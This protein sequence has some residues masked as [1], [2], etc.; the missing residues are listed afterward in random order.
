VGI[1]ADPEREAAVGLDAGLAAR[2]VG[3][4]ETLAHLGGGEGVEL[5]L[6]RCVAG[7]GRDDDDLLDAVE[8]GHP[9]SCER[10]QANQRSRVVR[11]SARSSTPLR[12]RC[13]RAR[14]RCERSST[15]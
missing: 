10:V 4:V 1:E 13:Q 9:P 12:R 6:A 11:T 14:L 7:V 2:G 3:G 5:D 15:W 8:A